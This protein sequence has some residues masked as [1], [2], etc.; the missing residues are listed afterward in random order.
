MDYRCI[1][2]AEKRA[3]RY[4]MSNGKMSED[5]RAEYIKTHA[6]LIRA[7]EVLTLTQ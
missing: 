1:A 5:R 3:D 7:Q 4:E 6:T 2:Q